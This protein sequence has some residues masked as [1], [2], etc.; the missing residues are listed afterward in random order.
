MEMLA[1]VNLTPDQLHDIVRQE[2]GCL[3]W[4]GTARLAPVDD[5]LISVERP[6]GIDSQG[7]MVASILSKKLAAGSTHLLI[8]IPVGPTAKVRHMSQALALRKLFEFVGDRLNIHLEVMITDGRQPIGRGIGPVLEARDIMQVLQ[9]DPDAPA[10][11]RVLLAEALALA[12][13]SG[14]AFDPT[15]QPLWALYARHFSSPGADPEGPAADAI[16]RAKALIDWRNVEIENAGIRLR[17]PAMAITLNGIAQGYITDRVGGLLQ[18][19]GFDH[20]LVNMGEELALGPKWDGAAWRVGIANPAAPETLLTELSLSRGAI[21]TSGGYGYHFD[22][23]GR[24]THILDPSTGA[25]A[26]RWASVTVVTDRA[27]AADGLS[28]ALTVAPAARAS[29]ILPHGAKAYVVSAGS[30]GYWL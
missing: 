8:D 27:A 25:P 22:P 10:D 17:E 20:V 12:E 30:D 24:F 29:Q 2:R 4:G 1:E 15:V 13:L 26:R 16:V 11:L 23:A 14:G 5:M 28:T 19:R 6:L 21:A 9:N 18:D 7:Q 3:A